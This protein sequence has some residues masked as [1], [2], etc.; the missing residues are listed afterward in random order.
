MRGKK[1]VTLNAKDPEDYSI[2]MKLIAT[3][4]IIV[5]N[6]RPDV[7]KRMGVSYDDVIKVKPDIIIPDLRLWP[8]QSLSK[9]EALLTS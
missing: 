3:A 4:D 1:S 6:F 2:L 9:T 8:G 7:T 5:E